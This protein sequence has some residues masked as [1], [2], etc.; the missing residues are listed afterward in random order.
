MSHL[1]SYEDHITSSS[2][3]FTQ[4]QESACSNLSESENDG[5]NDFSSLTLVT[6]TSLPPAKKVHCDPVEQKP[7]SG[8]AAVELP[9]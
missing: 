9:G 8:P 5:R 1:D 6:R 4:D 2:A 3:P 7:L